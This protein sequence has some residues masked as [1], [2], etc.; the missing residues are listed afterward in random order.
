MFRLQ[1]NVPEIYTKSSRD[2]QLF[3]RLY[4][5]IDNANI[6]NCKSVENLLNPMKVLD[7]SVTLLATRIGF[8]PKNIYNTYVLRHILSIFP[9]SIKYKGS[10]KGI[11]MMVNAVMRAE[12]NYGKLGIDITDNYIQI[13][14]EKSIQ[15][16]QLL[17]DAL[18]Y[19]IPIGYEIRVE[20]VKE[21]SGASTQLIVNEV[22]NEDKENT[23][24]LA[25]INNNNS[26]TTV[27]FDPT[28]YEENNQET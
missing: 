24:N 7:N 20:L 22:H 3:C 14:I 17:L 1:E 9:Y 18:S 13:Q 28:V 21:F 27:S 10:K 23:R 6:F 25:K 11:F 15:N 12:Q 2:F 4:D 26:Y 5:L 19:I 16:E 8:F